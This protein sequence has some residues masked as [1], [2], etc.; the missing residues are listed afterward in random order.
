MDSNFINSEEFKRIFSFHSTIPNR[1]ISRESGWLEFKESFNWG[2]KDKYA[3]S[4]AAFSNNKG[5][6][7]IFGVK[8]EPR[9]LIGLKSDN[10][11]T[12]DEEKITSYLNNVFSPEIKYEKDIINIF[13]KKIGILYAQQ[14]GIKPIVCIKNDGELKESDIY[15]RYN[16]RSE[17]IKYPELIILLNEIRESERKSWMEHLEKISKVGP[18]N[19]AI[20]DIL[21][22]EISGRG[23]TLV[24]DK[25]L[26]PK[27]KFIKEGRFKKKGKP[28]L[29]LIG[30]VKPV[31]VIIGKRGKK[32]I[33][34]FEV[35]ITDNP[36]APAVRLEEE[37][38]LKKYPLDYKTLT[39]NLLSR[40]K[41]FKRDNKY[42]KLKRDFKKNKKLCLIRYLDP[43]NPK[44]PKKSFYSKAIYK[45][46]DKYYKKI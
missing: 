30:D 36:N 20:L 21:G 27:L 45:E 4:L 40:Y 11:E 12:I 42:H 37:D 7:I 28:V 19:T 22:G 41:D 39:S 23:G 6:Y 5:G 38:M 24:I 17:K 46:F 34:D 33:Q 26:V 16:A 3:K 14:A 8:N 18:L 32:S 29:R 15:Y 1:I 35:K 44:S 25:K 43:K 31:S 2:S 13:N 9:E 10:F